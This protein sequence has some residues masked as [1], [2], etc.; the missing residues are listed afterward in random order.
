MVGGCQLSQ[1]G[2]MGY[3]GGRCK[4]LGEKELGIPI[5][6]MRGCD[7]KVREEGRRARDQ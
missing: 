2:Y 7:V 3:V 4:V 1:M 6:S 5:W